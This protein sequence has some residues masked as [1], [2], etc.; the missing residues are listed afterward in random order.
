MF[1]DAS[2]IKEFYEPHLEMNP[3]DMNA[4]GL[5]DKDVVE[6]FNDR[7]SIQV[8]VRPSESVRPG[9]TRIFE[10][11]WTKYMIKGNLQDLTND[12]LSPRDGVLQM[13]TSIA[14]QDT[15]V[16]VRKA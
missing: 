1:C 3:V 4:R 10:G 2:W 9:S 6:V 14:F 7:G 5:V 11:I 8:E 13:G 12:N 16:E 15:L